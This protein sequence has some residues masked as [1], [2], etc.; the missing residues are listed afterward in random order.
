MFRS[1]WASRCARFQNTTKWAIHT[2]STSY[3]VSSNAYYEHVKTIRN[4]SVKFCFDAYEA[5][6]NLAAYFFIIRDER[7]VNI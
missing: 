7:Y 5:I 3:F 4:M 2:K 1:L 6:I